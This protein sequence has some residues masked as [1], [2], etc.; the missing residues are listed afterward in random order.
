MLKFQEAQQL[1]SSAPDKKRGKRLEVNTRLIKRNDKFCIT[2]H[3]RVIIEILKD[4]TY[5]VRNN[6]KFF[7]AI[8][9]RINSY[10]PASVKVKDSKWLLKDNFKFHNGARI[11]K[12]GEVIIPQPIKIFE[13]SECTTCG[14]QEENCHCPLSPER[15]RHLESVGNQ[16]EQD[17]GYFPDNIRRL[18]R[19]GIDNG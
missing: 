2:F 9:K 8:R 3:G 5:I 16:H 11:N 14:L 1:F 17:Y 13:A 15:Y 6:G 18:L 12:D 4:D 7:N 10:T 19:R